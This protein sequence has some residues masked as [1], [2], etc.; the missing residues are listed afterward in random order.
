VVRC[1]KEASRS[2][3]SE[4]RNL[5]ELLE[6]ACGLK[7]TGLEAV[8]AGPFRFPLPITYADAFAAALAQK[9]NCPLVTGDLELQVGEQLQI[10]WI[11]SSEKEAG[12]SL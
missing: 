12:P 8:I 3:E 11:G 10:E 4:S 9:Y 6:L 1:R 5:A 7:S 2:R